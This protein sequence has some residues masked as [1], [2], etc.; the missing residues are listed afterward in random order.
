MKNFPILGLIKTFIVLFIA[1]RP[2]RKLAR[3]KTREILWS[4]YHLLIKE[5][6]EQP[7]DKLDIIK[8]RLILMYEEKEAFIENNW[9]SAQSDKKMGMAIDSFL[10]ELHCSWIPLLFCVLSLTI[11]LFI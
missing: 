4:H 7:N 11:Y 5:M 2:F 10:E 1:G 8:N 6:K 9:Q 3:Q